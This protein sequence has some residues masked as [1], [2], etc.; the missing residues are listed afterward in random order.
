MAKGI[1]KKPIKGTLYFALLASIIDPILQINSYMDR[2]KPF[3]FDENWL[4]ISNH[5]LSTYNYQWANLVQF[6]FIGSLFI[7]IISILLIILF[8]TRTKYFPKMIIISFIFRTLLLTL[9]FYFRTVIKGPEPPDLHE[10]RAVG[11]M[12]LTFAGIWVPY[13]LLSERVNE[14]FIY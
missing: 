2:I 6:E 10:I 7:F 4:N 12:I 11:G 13:Y 8:F 3:S 5:T 9:V 14:T 1:K